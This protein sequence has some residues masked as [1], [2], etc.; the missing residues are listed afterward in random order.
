[1]LKS[2][3]RFIGGPDTC[4]LSFI[5]D[6]QAKTYVKKFKKKATVDHTELFP[7]IPLDGLKLMR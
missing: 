1:M 3:L 4:D 5:T 6:N 2:V 7:N